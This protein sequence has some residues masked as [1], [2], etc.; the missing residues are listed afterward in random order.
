M[1]RL[2]NLSVGLFLLLGIGS[3]GYLAVNF[4]EVDFFGDRRYPVQAEFSSVAGLK[5]NTAVEMSGISVGRVESI[6]LE[7]YRARV[8]M[9]I[10]RDVDL[11]EDTIATI[12]TRGL[13]GENYVSLNPGGLSMTISKD[14]DGWIQD[15]Q[16]PIAFDQLIAE[17]VFGGSEGGSDGE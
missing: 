3:L 6:E 7:D 13:L 16:P 11:P 15:T 10:D 8:T 14:G 1:E 9:M 5:T 12:R 4:G 2:I 17:F